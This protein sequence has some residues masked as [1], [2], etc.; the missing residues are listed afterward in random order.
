MSRLIN[1]SLLAFSVLFPLS[2][3]AEGVLDVLATAYNSNPTLMAARAGLRA[4]DEQVPLAQ[5]GWRPSISINGQAGRGEYKNNFSSQIPYVTQRSVGDYAVT[6][7]QPVFQGGR[8]LAQT[9]GAEALVQAGR[10]QLAQAENQVLLAAATAYLDVARDKAVLDLHISNEHVLAHDLEM[11]EARYKVGEIT[12]TDVAQAQARLAQAQAERRGAEG[13]LQVSRAAFVAQIGRPPEG[14][15]IPTGT[16]TLPAQLDQA[17]TQAAESNPGIALAHWQAQAA[18]EQVD[19]IEGELLPSVAL[20]G[21]LGRNVNEFLKGAETSNASAMVTVSVPL[22]EGGGTYARIRAQKQVV[23]Q[24]LQELDRARR[25]AMQAVTQGWELAIAAQARVAAYGSQI[26]ASDLALKGVRAE[27]SA[28]SRTTI[29]VL[30][31]EQEMFAAKVSEVTARR[32][33]WVAAYQTQA[34][35]GTLNARDLGLPVDQYDPALHYTDSRW[36]WLGLGP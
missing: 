20:Q 7:T 32:D 35:T 33:Q 8:T 25:D 1:R 31:A 3:R 28:G 34:A 12:R 6:L 4:T 10:A 21:S 26:A 29:E 23:G 24:R 15:E 16:P 22:Y 27:A 5:S 9:A 13:T 18:Q 19:A 36:R 30:N 2:A 17:R 11:T 14:A